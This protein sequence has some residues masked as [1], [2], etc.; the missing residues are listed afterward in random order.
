[1]LAQIW[2]DLLRVER[3]GIH[4]NFFELGGDSIISLQV[5]SRAQQQGI[6]I[7]PRQLFDTPT[8]AALAA[9]AERVKIIERDEKKDDAELVRTYPLSPMQKGMLFESVSAPESGVYIQQ[10]ICM[11]RGDLDIRAFQSAWQQAVQRHSVLRTSF[12]WE[13]DEEPLQSVC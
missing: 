11:L 3:I 4:D 7:A 13:H 9:T 8:I 10:L 12:L 2:K 6:R 1:L 5:M